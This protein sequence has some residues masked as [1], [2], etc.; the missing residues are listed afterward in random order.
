MSFEGLL[1][2][3]E[4][5][6]EDEEEVEEIPFPDEVPSEYA[7]YY[8]EDEVPSSQEVNLLEQQKQLRLSA[9]ERARVTQRKR[10]LKELKRNVRRAKMDNLRSRFM[11]QDTSDKL[12]NIRDRLHQDNGISFGKGA[13]V[14]WTGEEKS[15]QGVD[16]SGVGK[17][18]GLKP[19]FS[20]EE[21]RVSVGVNNNTE[22]FSFGSKKE[23]FS[24]G[25]N[26]QVFSFG[27]NKEG[28]N[29]GSKKS[30]DIGLM[31]NN[32][33]KHTKKKSKKKSRKKSKR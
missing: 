30:V 32:K 4:D 31:F 21:T 10:R 29:F 18:T 24:F 27:S 9:Q 15:H 25:K 14:D 5:E 26:K 11:S 6:E 20:S 13:G 12:S 17:S 16:W 2:Q 8:D 33:T 28:F 23:P 22:P 3:E 19:I 7:E 1:P